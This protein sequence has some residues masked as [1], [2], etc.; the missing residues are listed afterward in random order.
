[1]HTCMSNRKKT[2]P[3]LND[4]RL[5]V[6]IPLSLAETIEAFIERNPVTDTSKIVRKALREYLSRH[7]R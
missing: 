2:A 7:S 4:I 3:E 5:H 1:M 6:M